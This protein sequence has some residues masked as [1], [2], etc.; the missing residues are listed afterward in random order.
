MVCVG[1]DVIGGE[2]GSLCCGGDLIED[3]GI[4]GMTIIEGDE[5]SG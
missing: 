3:G 1:L 5:A 2:V 4:G